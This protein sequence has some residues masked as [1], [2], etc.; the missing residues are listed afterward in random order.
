M[1]K[2]V[3][4]FNPKKHAAPS[5]MTGRGT[6]LQHIVSD[7]LSKH[8]DLP[9]TSVTEEFLQT[10]EWERL[11]CGDRLYEQGEHGDCMHILL[12]GR[13]KV[14]RQRGAETT[15]LG[16]I[17]SG[18]CVG[19]MSLLSDRPRAASIFAARDSVL[20]KITK[21]HFQA[22]CIDHPR[23][24]WQV[25][26]M[27]I[28]RLSTPDKG[29]QAP[30]RVKNIAFIPVGEGVN[31]VAFTQ[32]MHDLLARTARVQT[33]TENNVDPFL[34]GFCLADCVDKQAN[35]LNFGR[36]LEQVEYAN[37]YVI[38]QGNYA[39]DFWTRSC[40]RQADTIILVKHFADKT[41]T[42]LSRRIL[43]EVN[44][45]SYVD[46][47]LVLLH[48]DGDTAPTHTRAHTELPHV[49]RHH[50]VRMDRP[51]DYARLR[52]F[53]TGTAV[54]L[55]L[56]GGGAKGFAHIGI[57]RRL[58]E[59]NV[60]IDFVGGTSIGACMAA[61]VAGDLDDFTIYRRC[62]QAFVKDKPLSDRTLPLV[63]YY[64]GRKLDK[65]LQRHLGE[66]DIE[67]Q[68]LNFF[69]ISSNLTRAGS[70]VHR[71]GSFWRAVRAS[72]SLPGA[73]PPVVLDNDLLVDGGLMNNVPV[74]VMATMGVGQIIAVDLNMEKAYQLDYD[75]IPGSLRLLRNKFTARKKRLKVPGMMSI[76]SKSIVLSS[77]EK[78][79]TVAA[80][81]DCYLR[82][83]V[84]RIGMLDF[85]KYDA[86][87]QL[88]YAYLDEL[89][90]ADENVLTRLVGGRRERNVDRPV[91]G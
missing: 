4:V 71:R 19:E 69:C 1:S 31:M 66:G 13:L 15:T 23:M 16:E 74:D 39:D 90:E 30:A 47:T 80:L 10:L 73:F 85:K 65:G 87:V 21:A 2:E 14:I 46:K 42:A 18:E 59:A 55:V 89:L 27:V 45:L 48:P 5:K 7:V 57:I 75:K 22:L 44:L 68:W 84:Q 26:R 83:P 77:F 20:V 78:A 53:L 8:W 54:G 60:P 63:S 72:M 50:H 58:R 11:A 12:S 28:D 49:D 62:K 81:A 43:R 70:M 86:T 82:P 52:R 79:G 38:Y 41:P 25:S 91:I 76:L 36:C 29:R 35:H 32:R 6:Y 56:G 9:S 33:L 17:S 51:T 64:S 40:V 67:D 88:G 34:D 24:L 37:D 3:P 61:C